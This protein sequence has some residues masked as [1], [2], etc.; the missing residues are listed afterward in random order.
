MKVSVNTKFSTVTFPVFVMLTE[1]VTISPLSTLPFWK[2]SSQL[3]S[4][5]TSIEGSLSMEILVTSSNSPSVSSPS[6][7]VLLTVTPV[8]VSVSRVE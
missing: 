4:F 5:I 1:N 3:Q 7:L 6:L 8:K 2:T